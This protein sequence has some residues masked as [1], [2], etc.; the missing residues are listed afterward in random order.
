MTSRT[1]HPP[2]PRSSDENERCDF[3]F[4]VEREVVVD[5][6]ALRRAEA[7]PAL[8]LEAGLTSLTMEE[9][10][11]PLLR[12]GT[13]SDVPVFEPVRFDGLPGLLMS[14]PEGARVRVNGRRAPRVALLGVGDQVQHDGCVL[15]L[16]RFRKPRIGAPPAELVGTA[17][18]TCRTPVLE[19]ARVVVHDCGAPIHLEDESTPEE[20]RFECALVGSCPRC[21]QPV[22]LEA[23]YA[24]LPELL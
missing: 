8:E 1:I 9:G 24:W 14:T 21:E 6:A 12:A 7:L 16:T 23:G 19:D 3:R 20:R 15:H 13:S 10:A 11:Q 22:D 4:L 17:C 18:P 2:A 5:E